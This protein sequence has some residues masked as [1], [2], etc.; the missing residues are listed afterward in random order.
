M[1]KW[2]VRGYRQAYSGLP[3]AVWLLA[4]VGL[5]N[6]AGTMVLPLGTSLWFALFSTAVWTLGEMLVLPLTNAVAGDRAGSGCIGSYMGAYTVSFSVA[7]IA[8]PALGTW[9]YQLGG[10]ELV[11]GIC[12]RLAIVVWIGFRLLNPAFAAKTP[13]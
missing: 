9:A 12:G 10:G 13:G 3:R 11:W 2:V 6:R 1:L 5:V 4:L 7:F 8:G